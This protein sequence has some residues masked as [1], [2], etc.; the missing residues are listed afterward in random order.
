MTNSSRQA[1]QGLFYKEFKGYQDQVENILAEMETVDY[2]TSSGFSE[3]LH[4]IF[5]NI[6]GASAQV[7]L[8]VLSEMAWVVESVLEDITYHSSP[9]L[10]KIVDF[11]QTSLVVMCK[12]YDNINNGIL[13]PKLVSKEIITALEKIFAPEDISAWPN[14]KNIIEQDKKYMGDSLQEEKTS[15]LIKL[16]RQYNAIFLEQGVGLNDEIVDDIHQAIT[17]LG[18]Y[19]DVSGKKEKARLFFSLASLLGNIK[20]SPQ[21]VRAE[22]FSLIDHVL[23]FLDEVSGKDEDLSRTVVNKM[24]EQISTFSDSLIQKSDAIEGLGETFDE[25]YTEEGDIFTAG[26]FGITGD[27]FAEPSQ[28]DDN[29]LEPTVDMDIFF[30]D[31]ASFGTGEI[32]DATD[33]LFGNDFSSDDTSLFIEPDTESISIAEELSGELEFEEV[34]VDDLDDDDLSLKEIFHAECEDHVASINRAMLQIDENFEDNAIVRR[35]VGDLR[36][37]IHTLKGA[38]GMTGFTVLADFAHHSEDFLDKLYETSTFVDVDINNLLSTIV[39]TIEDLAYRSEQVPQDKLDSVIA[40]IRDQLGSLGSSDLTEKEDAQDRPHIAREFIDKNEESSVSTGSTDNVLVKIDNIDELQTL[41]GDIVT[42]RNAMAGF[43]N[44]VNYALKEL[45]N[46]KDKLKKISNDLDVG[47]E[48][49]ALQGFGSGGGELEP[50][51]QSENSFDT[52]ELDRYSELS[53]IIRSLNETSIDL[54][55]LHSDLTQSSNKIHGQLLQ[56]E[57]VARITQN[58]LM[59][60][61]M[62]PFSSIS[63]IFFQNVRSTAA[64]LNKKVQLKIDGDDVYLDKFIWKKISDPIMHILRNSIDHGLES[65]EDRLAIGK[66]EVGTI[67]IETIQRGN[68]VVLRISDDGGGI[69]IDKLREILVSKNIISKDE[70]ISDDQLIQY[71]FRTGV[72]T[73]DE[74]TTISGRGVGLDVV[75]K[76][77]HDLKGSVLIRTEPGKG[78]M[79]EINVPISLSINKAIIVKDLDRLFAIPTQDVKE[80]LAYE[81]SLTCDDQD[82]KPSMIDWHGQQL[83]KVMLRKL[84]SEGGR[85]DGKLSEKPLAIIVSCGDGHRAVIVDTVRN[86]QEIVIKDLG[87][88]LHN[89]SGVSGVT[90]FGDGELIPI[91]NL[92]GLIGGGNQQNLMIRN[93]T[94]RPPVVNDSV[95]ILIV[96]DSISV[97]QTVQ[98]L[99]KK[100]GWEVNVAIDGIDALEKLQLF[101]PDIIV[102]DIEM[103]RMNGY[104]LKE[105]LNNIDGLSAIPVVMLTSRISAKHK[106]VAQELGIQEYVTK[107]YKEEDFINLVWKL[108]G[109]AKKEEV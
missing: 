65:K 103:P 73:K 11:I 63:R 47:F 32:E 34:E 1:L 45:E 74:V 30:D 107:P 7:A 87:T 57:I 83:E 20:T 101:T 55:S 15:R 49:Q 102:S 17:G 35:S 41:G 31:D 54:S 25:D 79:F 75:Q 53:L 62:T 3:E 106:I 90:D 70:S 60:I 14:V 76:N 8:P 42:S 39:N 33:A 78:T 19:A 92:E 86:Q 72:T 23:S 85:I 91:L 67:T 36:R 26:D 89:L 80:I 51:A 28:I 50:S 68:I 9:F 82:D 24:A 12:Y 100:Q 18:E 69:N 22:V 99:F 81:E 4:R 6:K 104:E 40:E 77:I 97:R 98:R 43:L 109:Q 58:R 52:M 93:E 96:D 48:I 59:R 44:E 88:H 5:H 66:P 94:S 108:A 46:T 29:L 38:A 10:E 37:V 27:S 84:V 16:L 71:L 64:G 2:S 61:R 13:P 105:N 56:Q 95:R 21:E